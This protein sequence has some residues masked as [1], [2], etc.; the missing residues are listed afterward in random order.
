MFIIS[1]KDVLHS[2]GKVIQYDLALFQAL[3]IERLGFLNCTLDVTLRSKFVVANA[4]F[5]ETLLPL[6]T[7]EKLPG[8]ILPRAIGRED[9]FWQSFAGC[10]ICFDFI[11]GHVISRRCQ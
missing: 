10:E 9:P 5:F 2:T 4:H 1:I 6:G 8:S 7:S 3:C 11:L